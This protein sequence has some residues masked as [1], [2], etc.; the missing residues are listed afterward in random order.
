MNRL[1]FGIIASQLAM[2]MVN[3][4]GA[5][6]IGE[7]L[8]PGLHIV[9]AVL[10]GRDLQ[11]QALEPHTVVFAHHALIVLGKGQPTTALSGLT[12]LGPSVRCA[13]LSPS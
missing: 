2:T 1:S 3:R 9:T 8:D 6:G 12:L 4:Q 5:I 7:D 13:V 10:I 11:D